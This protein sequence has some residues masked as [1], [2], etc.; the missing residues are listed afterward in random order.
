L[1]SFSREI[2]KNAIT[3]IVE[4]SSDIVS[5]SDVVSARPR[6]HGQGHRSQ[7]PRPRPLSM[8]PEQKW[9]CSVCL[10]A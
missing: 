9:R 5:A 2:L 4:D 6:L 1:F 3:I 7:V 8:W 10:A